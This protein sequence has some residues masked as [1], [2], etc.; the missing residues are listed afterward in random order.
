MGSGFELAGGSVALTA[1]FIAGVVAIGVGAAEAANAEPE[2][3]LDEA[4]NHVSMTTSATT[5]AV[6]QFV[7]RVARSDGTF[8]V[9]S[10]S[11]PE[12][13]ISLE[14]SPFA[15]PGDC[16]ATVT[17]RARAGRPPENEMR[18]ERLTIEAIPQGELFGAAEAPTASGVIDVTLMP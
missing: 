13:R 11:G 14:P 1:G 2:C 10:V 16:V 3:S 17:R 12:V 8:L 15:C 9:R 4:A 7:L 5:V 18:H 6:D